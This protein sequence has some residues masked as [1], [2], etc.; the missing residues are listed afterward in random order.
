[1]ERRRFAALVCEILADEYTDTTPFLEFEN[2]FQLLIA[3]ILSAQTTDAQVNRVTPALFSRFPS[4]DALA[5]ANQEEV[6]DLIR[7]T[8]FFRSKARNI[9]ACAAALN[10]RHGGEVPGTMSELTALPG[11]GRKTAGVLMAVVHGE[12]AIIVDTHFSRVARRLGLTDQKDPG[13][14]EKEIAGC[15]DREIWS[16]L[17]MLLNR[18]GRRYCTARSPRCNACPLRQICSFR[19]Q[20]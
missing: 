13:K 12:P 1:M 15:V 10:E 5:G 11:V 8:G 20:S 3:V 6:E 9:V 4:S 16:K 7:S 2:E 19:S 18:H 14:I 17:S